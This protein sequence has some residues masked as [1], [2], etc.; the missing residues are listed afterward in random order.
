M[1]EPGGR[2]AD[3]IGPAQ[4][5]RLSEC[6]RSIGDKPP[7][8][9][10]IVTHRQLNRQHRI[11]ART[12]FLIDS[13]AL[14]IEAPQIQAIGLHRAK[15]AVELPERDADLDRLVKLKPVEIIIANGEVPPRAQAEIDC[16]QDR[17]FTTVSRTDQA[18]DSGQ[19]KP[20]EPPNR[21]KVP[22]FD[23]T[24][25]RHSAQCLQCCR[26]KTSG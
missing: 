26:A 9:F 8:W 12:W 24:N 19:R 16:I 22:D 18:V 10:E 4:A 21:P 3:T 1:A 11:E 15:V 13:A 23:F 5:A 2:K 7:L 25:P 20:V 17:R 14:Q 6:R